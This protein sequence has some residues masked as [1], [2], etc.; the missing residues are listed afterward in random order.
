MFSSTRPYVFFNAETGRRRVFFCP[1]H[2]DQTWERGLEN[3]FEKNL[4]REQE[5][6]SL[7]IK[8]KMTLVLSLIFEKNV[9]DL[10]KLEGQTKNS[11]PPRLC[12][13][14]FYWRTSI[15]QI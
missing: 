14:K 15:L 3:F 11:A 13:E 2:L 1:Q 8:R 10:S 6:L 12:V 9:S 7:V 4:S 5:F